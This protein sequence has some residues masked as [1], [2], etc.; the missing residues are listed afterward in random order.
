MFNDFFINP[1]IA[2]T[3][4]YAPV[5]LT[6]R[7][8]WMG[9]QDGPQTQTISMHGPILKNM[10]LGGILLNDITGPL[11]QTGLQ[12]SYSYHL[13]LKKDLNLSFGLAGLFFE[14]IMDQDKIILDDPVDNA[15]IGGQQKTFVPEASFGMLFFGKNYHLGFS[16]PQLLQNKID[17]NTSNELQMN[18]LVRHYFLNA[19]YQFELN[20]KIDI[21][22]S[23]LFKALE[24]APSQ[25]DINAK[26]TYD[27]M[28]WLGFSYRM[29]ESLVFLLGTEQKKIRFGYSYD[30]TLTNI[31]KHSSGSHEVFIAYNLPVKSGLK[32]KQKQQPLTL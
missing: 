13:Y 17:F 15:L 6:M 31:R 10:G 11:R 16:V 4:G 22:P 5:M 30:V 32:T 23:L 18:R 20:N 29:E 2:G 26:I 1:A 28:A 12:L 24:S 7:N 21:E 14:H 9:L 8:Q 3:K 27:K 19:G 25:L